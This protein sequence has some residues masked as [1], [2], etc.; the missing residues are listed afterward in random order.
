MKS[1]REWIMENSAEDSALRKV[2]GGTSFAIDASLKSRLKPKI[3]QIVKE[4][5]PPPGEE[6]P[7]GAKG[8]DPMELFRQILA[9]SA[10]VIGDLHGTRVSAHQVIDALHNTGGEEV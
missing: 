9:V 7:A 10:S 8:E 1:I 6:L 4:F 2:M 5:A 3:E